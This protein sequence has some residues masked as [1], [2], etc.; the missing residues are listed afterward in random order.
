MTR[1]HSIFNERRWVF[2]FA[3]LVMVLTSI[4]YLV[5][6]ARQGDDWIFTGFVF[7]V[8]DGNSYI[9]KMLGGGSGAWLF[10]TPYTVFPQSGVIAY[11]PYILLGKLI[12][13]SDS[14]AHLVIIYHL[15]RVVAG[16]LVI[17]ATYDFL[18][19]YLSDV[20][21][22]RFGL[23]LVIL[24]GGLGW[25]FILL[26]QDMVIG[27]IPLDFYSPETFGFLSLYGIPHLALARATLLWGLLVYLKASKPGSK[28]S[29]Q[30]W[31]KLGGLWLLTAI[32]QPLT[33]LVM[34]FVIGLHLIALALWEIWQRYKGDVGSWRDWFH[35]L[36]VAILAGLIP[37]PFLIYNVFT[38][39]NDPYLRIWISQNIISSPH[40]FHYVMAYGLCLIFLIPGSVRMLRYHPWVGK[41]PVSWVL[42]F[43]LLAYI[44]LNIQRRLPEGVWVAIV[45]ITM[46]AFEGTTLSSR[47]SSI[48]LTK[49]QSL[50]RYRY[51]LLLAL[52]ST[53]LLIAGGLLTVRYLAQP[54]FRSAS[55]VAAF[56][57]LEGISDPGDIV[58]TSYE[59]GNALPAWVPVR[60]VSGHGPESAGSTEYLA[61]VKKFYQLDTLDSQRTQLLNNWSAQFVFW[62]PA[63]RALGDW[64]PYQANYLREI[65]NKNGF[66]IFKV[67]NELSNN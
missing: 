65:Y 62:G 6:Y 21:L 11:I 36:R 64:D 29:Y 10:R 59:T 19:F 38:F 47:E 60:V 42:V 5:G 16:F 35:A 58:L 32:A 2:I 13:P 53:L 31:V 61:Q 34:G 46:F 33:A 3:I 51:I 52:P 40:P 24:G 23:V 43:P 15:F 54:V 18:S 1:S 22:R 26:G 9:A 44:P 27:D 41:L 7:G 14:H 57:F 28:S 4:P 49:S 67:I 50:S 8:E 17:F 63:E 20:R 45:L 30:E 39:A 56:H 48:V 25:I 66:V 12:S 37:A 55:E